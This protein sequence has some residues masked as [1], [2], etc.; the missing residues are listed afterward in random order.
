MATTVNHHSTP[1]GVTSENIVGTIIGVIVIALLAI[2]FFVY[3]L[4][5]LRNA[6]TPSDEETNVTVP[7]K[8]NV[9]VNTPPATGPT[10]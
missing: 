3:G 9:D 6:A 7:D 8:I 2:T 5:T 1:A 10:Q 4:P